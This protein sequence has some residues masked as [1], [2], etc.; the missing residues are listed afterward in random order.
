MMPAASMDATS[1][2]VLSHSARLAGVSATP[3]GG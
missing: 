3:G 1:A 2:V